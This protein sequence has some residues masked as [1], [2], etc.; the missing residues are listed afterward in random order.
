MTLVQA[1]L[2]QLIFALCFILYLSLTCIMRGDNEMTSILP[3]A[4]RNIYFLLFILFFWFG[5]GTLWR[6]WSE[7]PLLG[8]WS[9]LYNAI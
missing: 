3:E 6:Q 4:D 5:L 9:Y 2:K 8:I 7:L 1:F